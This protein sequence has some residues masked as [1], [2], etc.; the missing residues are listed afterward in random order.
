MDLITDI[1]AAATTRQRQTCYDQSRAAGRRRNF[2]VRKID[3]AITS[4]AYS[5]KVVL[6]RQTQ[7]MASCAG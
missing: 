6:M 2:G 7:A 3:P 4:L 1:T 5:R